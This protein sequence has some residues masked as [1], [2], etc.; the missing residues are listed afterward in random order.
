MKAPVPHG[1]ISRIQDIVARETG[2]PLKGVAVA[3]L[4]NILA[5]I[6]YDPAQ[7]RNENIQS[8]EVTILLTDLRGFTSISAM[9]P[10][11]VIFD[12]LNQHLIKMSEIIVRHGGTINKFIGDSIMV[13]FGAP[14]AHH[15]DVKRA[16]ACAVDMQIA[17]DEINKYHRGLEL[18]EF[19]MGVGINTGNVMAGCLGSD[20]YAEYTVIGNEVNLAS[21]I[22][23]FSLR[24]QVLISKNTYERCR[25][26]VE[27]SEP[28]DVFVKGKTQAVQVYEVVSIPSLGTSPPRKEIRRSHRV[29][30]MIPFTYHVVEDK[31]VSSELRT[32]TIRDIS[33][34][35]VLAEM[36]C[37]LPVFSDIKLD[38]D[39]SLIG[40]TAADIYAKILNS[41]LHNNRHLSAIEFTSVSVQSNM[42][43]QQFVQL[44]VQGGATKQV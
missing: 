31:I 39:L 30:V 20:L 16:V 24:G 3:E 18:P 38:I 8:R 27:T 28:I 32:G 43:I 36:D 40:Y 29:E 33:Y 1:I 35:G 10:A 14:Y 11:A 25:D 13:L 23:A 5:D 9:H 19:Y 12:L 7:L 15:D 4:E 22:E 17:M 26:F 2:A 37:E 6:T 42:H 44:L 34:H 21:R 41:K